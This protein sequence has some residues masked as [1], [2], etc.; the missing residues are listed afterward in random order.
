ML[1]VTASPQPTPTVFG[2]TLSLDNN[3]VDIL[4][5]PTMS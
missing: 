2:T 5:D 1:V 3:V 4:G